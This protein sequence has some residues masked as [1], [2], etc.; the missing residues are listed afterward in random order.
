MPDLKKGE[1]RCYTCC[2]GYFINEEGDERCWFCNADQDGAM[3]ADAIEDAETAV[4][5]R[6]RALI[7]T[8]R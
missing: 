8:G 7:V 6:L 2:D 4:Y 1:W 5:N 3:P